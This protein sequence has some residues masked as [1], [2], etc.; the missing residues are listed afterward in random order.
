[1]NTLLSFRRSVTIYFAAAC[2]SVIFIVG[3]ANTAQAAWRNGASI[4]DILDQQ[5]FETLKFAL[6]ATNLTPVLESNYVTL[7]APTNDVFDA[8]AEALGCSSAVDLATRLLAIPVGDSDALTAV[9]TYHAV[10]GNIWSK[11][12]L[13]RKKTLTTV[14]GTD[15]STGVNMN[16]LY[17]K[18][19]ANDTASTITVEGLYGY[20]FTIYPINQI[21]LPF[22]AAGVCD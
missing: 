8:T 19:E 6:D 9:L 2:L 1:M 13:L 20:R 3:H 17:V 21:L 4:T 22:S 14:F 18:G 16:G 10:L 15:V 12:R 5:G 11:N 7:F